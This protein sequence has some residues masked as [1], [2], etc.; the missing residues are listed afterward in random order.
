MAMEMGM[1]VGLM[2][3]AFIFAMVFTWVYFRNIEILWLALTLTV[4]TIFFLQVALQ[5]ALQ[6]RACSGVKSVTNIFWG[7]LIGTLPTA[8]IALPAY[9]PSVAEIVASIFPPGPTVAFGTA[10]FGAFAG[11]MGIALGSL[12]SASC[13]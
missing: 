3:V 4:V 10:Y 5:T 6:A 11:A 12:Q 2:S 13:N 1:L 7:A 8:M 9:I